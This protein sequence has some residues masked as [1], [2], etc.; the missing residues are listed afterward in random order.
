MWARRLIVDTGNAN[1][2][3]LSLEEFGLKI[4]IG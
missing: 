3:D 2:I 4:V 1:A